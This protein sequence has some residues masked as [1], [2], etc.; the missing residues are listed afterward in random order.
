MSEQNNQGAYGQNGPSS[1]QGQKNALGMDDKTTSWFAYI[2][3]II[4]AIIVL[5]T[6]K[7][8]K[9]VRVHAWQSLF[10]GCFVWVIVI[11]LGIISGIAWAGLAW[12]F[13]SFLSVLNWL[14]SVGYIVLSVLCIVKAAQGDIFK[15]PVIYAQAE[16]MN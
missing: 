12:G 13:A 10:L 4:S 7:D 5:A 9:A 14:I 3:S 11:V 6:V 16:K 2:I 15:L 8:N 1:P